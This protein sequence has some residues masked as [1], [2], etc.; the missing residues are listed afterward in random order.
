MTARQTPKRMKIG[1]RLL[2]VALFGVSAAGAQAQWYTVTGHV[3]E[4][5]GGPLEGVTILAGKPEKGT[6]TNEKG[7]FE[8]RLPAGTH[9]FTVRAVGYLTKRFALALDRD[10]TLYLE[11]EGAATQLEQ[12]I[13]TGDRGGATQKPIGIATLNPAVLKTIPAA[14]GETDLLRGLQM[15]PGVSTV[16]E[17]SNGINVRGGTTDQNL[18]LLDETPIFNP[19]HLFGLFSVFPSDAVA[20]TELYKGNVPSRFGGRASSVLDVTLA[21]PGMDSFSLEGGI[22]LVSSRIL[23]DIPIIKNELGV[24]ISGRACFT[25][26]LLPLLSPKDL[27]NIKANFQE[28]SMKAVYRPNPKN[29]FFLTTYFSNDFFQTDLLGTI[30]DINAAYTQNAYHT[31]N[32]NLRHFQSIHDHL[33]WSTSASYVDYRPGLRLP[34]KGVDNTV[35]LRSGIDYRSIRSNLDFHYD[36]HQAKVGVSSTY[37]RINPGELIPGA[38]PSVNPVQTQIEQGLESALFLEDNFQIGERIG[39]SAGLRYSFFMAL[40]PGTVRLYDPSLPISEVAVTGSREYTPWAVVKT[41]GGLEP[42]LGLR[43]DL[44]DLT[45]LKLAYNLMRQYIQT[46]TNTTTPLPISRWKTADLYFGPQVSNAF[47]LGWFHDLPNHLFELSVE[48]YYRHTDQVLDYK[49]GA[50]LLLQP[51]PETE[52][53]TGYNQSYGLE[54]MASKKKGEWTGWFTYAFSRSLN[55]VADIND[56]AL[57]PANY[58]RPHAMNLFLN[59]HHN[60]HH[61]FS[62]TF[63][64]STGRPYSSPNGTFSF[65]G[66]K[67]PFYPARNNDRLPDYHRLDFS[68]NILTTQAEESK[69][70]NY[71]T[72]SVYNLYGRKNPYSIYFN[73]KERVLKKYALNIFAAPIVSLAYTVKFR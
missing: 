19:T 69:W 23:M 49:Q 17:A 27:G 59:F 73:N 40:G 14:F 61:N 34:E 54:L 66:V 26:F 65:Q 24:K 6:F 58:D 20:K 18:L 39:V 22:G 51:Y 56:G 67:Y 44:S 7:V 9:P 47:S 30:A 36:R 71:W 72:F 10:T 42:R 29:S 33:S 38:S 46:V 2:L 5:W 8:L 16:G 3:S 62:F 13:I 63:T 32:A 70:K 50:N 25:D 35:E 1:F 43:Y 41:Y 11:L 4:A 68:W 52:I 37:Y 21:N 53:L 48:G 12:V 45:S 60:E 57:F 28:S 31:F 55:R 15:L 64:Y